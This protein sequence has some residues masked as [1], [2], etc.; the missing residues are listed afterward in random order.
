M[1]LLYVVRPLTTPPSPFLPPTSCL[2]PPLQSLGNMLTEKAAKGPFL[3]KEQFGPVLAWR[4]LTSVAGGVELL[5]A[6]Q[7]AMIALHPREFPKSAC[8]PLAG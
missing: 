5:Y 1:S 4:S 2:P 8:R 6:L 7:A 3:A